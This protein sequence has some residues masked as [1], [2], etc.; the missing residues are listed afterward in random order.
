[1]ES[2]RARALT[3]ARVAS[4]RLSRRR[5]LQIGIAGGSGAAIIT[6]GCLSEDES[7][8]SDDERDG[9]P[10]SGE[11]SEESEAVERTLSSEN[12]RDG[13]DGW[14]PRVSP[15]E[16]PEHVEHLIEGYTGE[17][18]VLPGDS[19]EF[20]VR[21][22][23]D[24]TYRIDV[25]RL[26][27]YDGDGGRLT[28]T[29]PSSGDSRGT[30][31]P[32]P[33]PDPET[34][35]V[36]CDW[37]V[38]DVLEVPVDWLSGL[39][40][41]RFVLT[42]GPE[43]GTS[44]THPFV[45]RPHPD[46][47]PAVLVQL[48]LATAQAYN[49]WGGKSLYDHT[50]EGEPANVVSHD[51]P[52]VNEVTFHLNYAVHLL[53]FLEQEGYDV[54]Y[55]CD[56]DVHRD[57][58]LVENQGVVLSAGHDEYWSRPQRLAFQR[59]VDA[60]SNVGFFGANIAYWQVRY[61][62]DAR[63]MVCYKHTVEDDPIQDERRTGLFRDV[64]LP[65]CEL[66]GVQG[67]GAGLYNFPNF[68][69]QE[70]AMDHPWMA[71]TGFEPGDEILAVV[72]PEWDWVRDDCPPPGEYTNFFHYEEGTSDLEIERP[73]DADAIAYNS[74]AGG[75][76][77]SAGTL[78]YT[79]AIDPDPDWNRGWPYVRVRE[80]APSIADPDPR[81]QEFTRNLLDDFVNSSR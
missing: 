45:V 74:E 36:A 16:R 50:S 39:Y 12:D 69:V 80:Y 42:S 76:V 25:Y 60:G 58:S 18:S 73:A 7:A 27:W 6:S 71:N 66:L 17:T 81:L 55:V 48:P 28:T 37:D 20:Y 70:D 10:N 13:D 22:D 72:G 33:E 44:T 34:G 79:R 31:Q 19:L 30:D 9:G 62:N 52:Y 64:G 1:M 54:A 24:W 75:T 61:E 8:G 49:G 57:P 56:S 32:I 2:I 51:R 3:G 21:T 23:D 78:G 11:E 29:I 35:E 14:K 4:D 68:T 53:R 41:A 15:S 5:W 77:F 67:W 26:G 43:A 47:D 38:T 40:L 63:S 65:E 46:R 59:A